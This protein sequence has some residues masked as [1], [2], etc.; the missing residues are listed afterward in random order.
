MFPKNTAF[1]GR[2]PNPFG[3]LVTLMIRRAMTFRMKIGNWDCSG[4]H[5]M[6]TFTHKC[7]MSISYSIYPVG[8]LRT[9]FWILQRV[10]D[11]YLTCLYCTPDTVIIISLVVSLVLSWSPSVTSWV[12]MSHMT[13]P[14][15]TFKVKV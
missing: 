8:I 15:A 10:I 7:E 13:N 3:N 4:N 11:T 1:W 9:T 2:K 12:G 5:N 6:I 14:E